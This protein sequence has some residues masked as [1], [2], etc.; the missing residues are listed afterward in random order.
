MAE[1]ERPALGEVRADQHFTQPPPRYSEASL[2]KKMEELGIGR[3]S[4][5]ASIL[6]VL[7]ERAY[8]RLEKRRFIPEDRGRLVT[9]FL[10][11]F[12]NRYVDTGFTA[13]LEEQLDDVSGGRVG[14]RDVMRAFWDAFSAAV[15]ET[16]DLKVSDVIEALDRDLGPHF[17]PPRADGSDP[18]LCP[19]CGSGRLGLRLGRHGSFIGCS[20]YPECRY[21]RKL[22]IEGGEGDAETLREG[23]RLLGQHPETGEDITVRRGP[24]GLYVQQGEAP[25]DPK[26][27]ARPKRASLPRGMNGEEI[28][29]AQAL[30]LLSLPRQIGLH[31]ETGE[32]IAAGLGRFGPYIRMGGVYASLDRDDDVLSVGLNRAVDLLARKLASVRNLGPHP[33]DSAPIT[34]RKGRFGPYVQHGQMVANLPRGMALEEVTAEQAIALLAEKGKVLRPRGKAAAKANGKGAAEA[35]AKAAKPAA[36]KAAAKSAKMPARKPAAAKAKPGTRP[37]KAKAVPAAKPRKAA[38]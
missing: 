3:P 26:S 29:L 25:E 2:V 37:A 21:T 17:F 11:S 35:R 1:G 33:K 20:N 34:V 16:R 15:E 31:P 14:W 18:R 28:T 5:Y 9:A 32:P 12:F 7:Q 6:S 24:Y 8:V 4:T 22:A 23:M 19:A 10:V 38:P 27:K 30:G 13:A 36:P